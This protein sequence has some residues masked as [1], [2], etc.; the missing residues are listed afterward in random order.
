MKPH[1][2][3]KKIN[4][5]SRKAA[6]IL[7]SGVA[8]VTFVSCAICRYKTRDLTDHLLKEHGLAVNE[9]RRL[10]PGWKTL[11]DIDAGKLPPKWLTEPENV[12]IALRY[13]L[14]G[15]GEKGKAWRH[16]LQV[17]AVENRISEVSEVMAR[18]GQLTRDSVCTCPVCE[19]LWI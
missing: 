1:K 19:G 8:G 17:L 14:N 7:Q 2:W 15:E 11:C 3:I 4:N 6:H 12:Q 9:Y 13:S 16:A 5:S 18:R 10:H